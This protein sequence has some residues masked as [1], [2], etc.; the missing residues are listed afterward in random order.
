MKLALA[1]GLV[2]V[3][4]VVWGAWALITRTDY[5]WVSIILGIGLAFGLWYGVHVQEKSAK[6]K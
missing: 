6:D 3:G 1:T 2:S 4:F 5:W